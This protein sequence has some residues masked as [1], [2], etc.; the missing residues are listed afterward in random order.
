VAFR[1]KP[2]RILVLLGIAFIGGTVLS[3]TVGRVFRTHASPTGFTDLFGR[4]SW[5]WRVIRTS[6]AY[7]FCDPKPQLGGV[8]ASKS[9]IPTGTQVQDSLDPVEP[10]A[11]DQRSPLECA[12]A[13]FGAAVAAKYG[14]EQGAG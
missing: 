10:S 7:V 12:L 2:L 14:C 11:H 13:Q 6:N 9:E 8:P 5:R 3:D 4:I 1:A